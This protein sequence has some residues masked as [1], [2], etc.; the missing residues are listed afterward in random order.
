MKINYNITSSGRN[1]NTV[2]W[3]HYDIPLNNPIKEFRKIV[4]DTLHKKFKK[5]SGQSMEFLYTY[6]ERSYEN[7]NKV[8]NYDIDF[9]VAHIDSHFFENEFEHCYVVQNLVRWCKKVGVNHSRLADLKLKFINKQYRNYLILSYNRL[10]DKEE[11]E[12]DDWDEYR[13][14]K[15]EEISK[16]FSFSNVSEFQSVYKDYLLIYNWKHGKHSDMQFSLETITLSNYNKNNNLGIE[17][18]KE[19]VKQGNNSNYVPWSVLQAIFLQKNNKHIVDLYNFVIASEFN[20]K[21]LWLLNFYRLIP[22]DLVVINHSKDL[23]NLYKNINQSLFLID[24]FS[25]INKFKKFDRACLNFI[26]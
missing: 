1:R 3:Y 2:S 13:R 23:L 6:L 11:F 12:F 15:D 18:L 9:F 5:Y 26:Q 16:A 10:R 17:I 7:K 20:S 21:T 19:I 14:L 22:D 4:W 8:Y 24:T 25:Y